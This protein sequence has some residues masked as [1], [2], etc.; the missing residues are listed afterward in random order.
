M[1]HTWPIGPLLASTQKSHRVAQWGARKN[2]QVVK[3][4][5]DMQ[6][7]CGSS[8]CPLGERLELAGHLLGQGAGAEV[9]GE[10]L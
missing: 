8:I 5:G 1:L 6:F 9:E 7:R 3:K 2:G 10:A 4:G